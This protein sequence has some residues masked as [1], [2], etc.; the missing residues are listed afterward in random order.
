MTTIRW[1]APVNGFFVDGTKWSTG[2][3]P[4]A[5]DNALIDASGI[6]TVISPVAE[7]VASVSLAAGATLEITGS[8]FVVGT[9]NSVLPPYAV[10]TYGGG[11]GTCVNNGTILVDP[12]A[13]L[14]IADVITNFGTIKAIGDAYYPVS[15]NT[16]QINL[17]PYGNSTNYGQIIAAGGNINFSLQDLSWTGHLGV[18]QTN[19]INYATIES[20][21]HGGINIF[22]LSL[23]GGPDT[24]FT[25]AGLIKVD[26]GGTIAV[27]A[28]I[29]GIGTTEIDDG[30]M[31][32]HHAGFA[33]NITFGPGNGTLEMEFGSFADHGINASITGSLSGFGPGDKID[34]HGL[35]FGANTHLTYS[36]NNDILSVSDGT[37]ST[38]IHLAGS[39]VPEGFH[40]ADDGHG[41]TVITY[42]PPQT[43]A[44]PHAPLPTGGSLVNDL[45]VAAAEMGGADPS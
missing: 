3:V 1:K 15:S 2:T 43:S 41:S 37:Y 33:Q 32:L 19:F 16:G 4:G 13:G 30:I 26:G 14:L 21:A 27:H 34:L 40:E 8:H 18:G 5:S 11:L 23:T 25:N 10:G 39:Y 44:P 36:P 22:G 17:E 35:T 24:S 45:S 28:A 6:Y 38:T 7:T 29:T 20:T 12:H 9:G 31:F 42:A